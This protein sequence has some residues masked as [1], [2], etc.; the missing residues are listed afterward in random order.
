MIKIHNKMPYLP[1]YTCEIT[2]Q[3]DD[4]GLIYVSKEY[5]LVH[6]LYYLGIGDLH[7]DK[8]VFA[9]RQ[10]GCTVGE[11]IADKDGVIEKIHIT[12]PDV[13]GYKED[14]NKFLKKYVGQKIQIPEENYNV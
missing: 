1:E 3:M 2:E 4:I 8:H 10:P 5:G 9:V 14:I 6:H 12:E 13:S 11:L 7:A